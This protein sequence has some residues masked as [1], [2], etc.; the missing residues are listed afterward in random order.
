[1]VPR[2]HQGLRTTV[3]FEGDQHTHPT[4][5]DVTR[6]GGWRAP[7]SSPPTP[8]SQAGQGPGGVG[9][10]QAIE[11]GHQVTLTPAPGSHRAAPTVTQGPFW[12]LESCRGLVGGVGGTAFV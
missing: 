3:S 12:N 7:G 2:P 11:P 8:V 4:E 1:M 5:G 10:A 9:G 6:R